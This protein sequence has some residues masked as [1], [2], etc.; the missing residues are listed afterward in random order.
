MAD[1]ER[2]DLPADF[3]RLLQQELSIEPSPEFAARVRHRIA[4]QRRTP[5]WRARWIP[6][7]GTFATIAS[8]TAA[9]VVPAI[10]RWTSVPVPPAPPAIRVASVEQ[11]RPNLPDSV[12]VAALTAAHPPATTPRATPRQQTTR[13]REGTAATDLPLVI[14]DDR[15]RAAMATLFRMM[16]QGRV[17]NDSFAATVPVSLDPIVDQV[18]A[19]TVA[20]VVVSAIQP[21]GV[22]PNNSER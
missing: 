18:G 19:I 2:V 12:A 17:S 16:E 1:N 7:I 21:G 10:A 22:L 14:I 9:L 8:L 20:P 11:P 5:W 4:E 15:Q 3:E 6:A 13:P